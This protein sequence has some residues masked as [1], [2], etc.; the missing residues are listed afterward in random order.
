MEAKMTKTTSLQVMA[1]EDAIIGEVE[2]AA[3]PERVFRALTDPA[4]LLHW[5]TDAVCKTSLWEMDARKG[6]NGDSRPAIPAGRLW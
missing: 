5:W 6:G 2:I 3:P 4:Q 1:G